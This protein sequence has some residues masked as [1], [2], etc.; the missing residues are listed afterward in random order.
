MIF[1]SSQTEYNEKILNLV[2]NSMK[3]VS[4]SERERERERER[5]MLDEYDSVR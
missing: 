1:V 5:E 4:V 2:Y 3:Q